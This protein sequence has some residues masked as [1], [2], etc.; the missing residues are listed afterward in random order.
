[1]RTR[2]HKD[3]DSGVWYK[4]HAVGCCGMPLA[5]AVVQRDIWPVVLIIQRTAW[6]TIKAGAV[7][8]R[9]NNLLLCL[10]LCTVKVVWPT[11]LHQ[12]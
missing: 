6:L 1:M 7:H 2:S 3:L 9:M 11:L 10:V 5:H 4:A 8:H 12:P